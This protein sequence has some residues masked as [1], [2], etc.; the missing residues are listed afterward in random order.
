ME[1]DYI[2]DGDKT[3]MAEER[4]NWAEDRTILANERTFAGWMRTGLASVAIALGLKAVF[5]DFD[6]TWA[7]KATSSVFIVVACY[8]FYS[9]RQ[10]ACVTLDRM[11]DHATSPKSRSSMT[12]T[13]TI[14]ALGSIM[15]GVILWLL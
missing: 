13:A 4:T 9:A 14:L 1:E 8:I 11:E 3:K 2:Y 5:G 7:A 6:P 10:Q 12:I 15:T